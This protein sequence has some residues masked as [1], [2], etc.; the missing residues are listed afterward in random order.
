VLLP[1]RFAFNG[2]FY[3]FPSKVT[4]AAQAIIY[5]ILPFLLIASLMEELK[6]SK[7]KDRDGPWIKQA[8]INWWPGF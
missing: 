2:G 8:L 7:K 4:L 5:M 1:Y 6:S 3:N